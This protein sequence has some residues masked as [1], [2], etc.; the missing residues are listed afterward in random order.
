MNLMELYS[1]IQKTPLN[2]A[3]YWKLVDVYKSLGMNNESAAFE[4]LIKNKFNDNNTN[5][6]K[7]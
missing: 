3:I 5:I 4:Y 7:K 6:D 2:K 1:K